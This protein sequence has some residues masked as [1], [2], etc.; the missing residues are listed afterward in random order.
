MLHFNEST[1]TQLAELEKEIAA[2]QEKRRALLTAACGSEVAHY[3]F[4]R[5]DGTPATLA[6]MF[7][8]RDELIVIHNMGRR[9]SYCTL[10]ADGFNGVA[11]HLA[12][13]A[14]FALVSPDPPDVQSAFAA[15]RGWSFPL[16]SSAANTFTDDMGYQEATAD[17]GT[18]TWPGVSVFTKDAS[19]TIR[20][21]ACDVFGPGDSYAGIWHLFE[22]LP[23][24]PGEWFPRLAY[25]EA[26]EEGA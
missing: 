23:G 5:S 9:C 14:A 10:W 4:I 12:D 15:S 25:G 7:G 26:V 16:Y 20:R 21:V 13:R 2:L 11:A 6:E 18:S 17:G 3:D 22:L 19:G 24:G 8:E 1:T